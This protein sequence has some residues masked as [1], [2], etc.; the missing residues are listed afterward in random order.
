MKTSVY[1]ALVSIAFINLIGVEV[2]FWVWFF[3]FFALLGVW[4]EQ[5][6]RPH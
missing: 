4:L 2:P 6:K 1:L 3:C 5:K